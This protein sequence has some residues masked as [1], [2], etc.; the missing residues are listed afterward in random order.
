MIKNKK[1]V[2]KP[3]IFPVEDFFLE[4]KEYIWMPL[5]QIEFNSLSKANLCDWD[6]ENIF[7]LGF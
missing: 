2:P 5:I 1:F 4:P 3:V 6:C 7:P